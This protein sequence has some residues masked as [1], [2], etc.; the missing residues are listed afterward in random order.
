MIL[1]GKTGMGEGRGHYKFS[2]ATP[3]IT[4]IYFLRL[5]KREPVHQ[6]KQAGCILKT[7]QQILYTHFEVDK[8]TKKEAG[9]FNPASS[10]LNIY[11]FT[12]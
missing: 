2:G 7:L 11:C 4:E 3:E 8:G 6:L 9:L 5:G 12:D 1:L 10:V